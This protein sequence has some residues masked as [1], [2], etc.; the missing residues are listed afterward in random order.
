MQRGSFVGKA[1]MKR[2][3]IESKWLTLWTS[4]KQSPRRLKCPEAGWQQEILRPI[5]MRFHKD[6]QLLKNAPEGGKKFARVELQQA[7][8]PSSVHRVQLQ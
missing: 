3:L 2:R 6:G 5:R 8:L 1:Q 4:A 7:L